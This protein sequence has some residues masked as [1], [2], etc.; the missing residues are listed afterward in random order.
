VTPASAQS[1]RVRFRHTPRWNRD[2]A[3]HWLTA[4][5]QHIRWGPF[6]ESAR[7]RKRS[8]ALVG[9]HPLCEP[10]EGGRWT[11]RGRL[12]ASFQAAERSNSRPLLVERRSCARG[13]RDRTRRRR[14]RCDTAEGTDGITPALSPRLSSEKPT[15]YQSVSVRRVLA[16]RGRGPC[17]A[18]RRQ[19]RRLNQVLVAGPT[20][21]SARKRRRPHSARSWRSPMI[22]ADLMGKAVN[23]RA[24]RP[25]S[26][27]RAPPLGT[28]CSRTDINSHASRGSGRK[29]TET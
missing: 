27:F 15:S 25:Q 24:R 9:V 16:F 19:A 8:F 18:L 17:S 28:R 29:Q 4:T 13:D 11:A 14:L 3:V 23:P 21:K 20:P 12:P 5:S 6:V 2:H 1:Q 26:E 7:G 10:G 22:A